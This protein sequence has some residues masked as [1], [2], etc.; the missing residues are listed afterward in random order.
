[1][2]SVQWRFL[3]ADLLT[4]AILAELQLVNVSFSQAL[5][6]AGT[7]QGEILLTGLSTASNA[8]NATIPGRTAIYAERQASDGTRVLLYGGILWNREYSSDNQRLKVTAREFESYFERRR[9]TSTINFAAVDQLTIAQTL[10]NNAQAVTGG[11]IGVIVPTN[12]SGVTVSKTYY[13]Y[14][15]KSV[16]SALQDLSRS[17]N[18]FDW[19]IKV[20][21][22]GSGNP[23]K[24]LYFNYPQSGVRYSAT[25][26]NAP[27]FE[28][29]AG[30][31]I[32]YTYPE[33]GAI[34]ANTI[35]AMGAGN[36]DGK[37]L[38]TAVD[39]T[40]VST[41]WPL[42]EDSVNYSDISD[43]TLLSNLAAGQIAAVSYPPTTLQIVTTASTAPV[44][45]TYN[46]G[47]DARVRIYDGARFPNGLDATYRITALSVNVG[48]GSGNSP[49]R[50]ILT[51]TLP[52]S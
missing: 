21:Y 35:Y 26:P 39:T 52:T 34:A 37:L 19:N 29:P 46:I 17:T 4:N 2:A 50:V 40:K 44:L 3:F 7:F 1:M 24:T 18:G 47:D 5:N 8:I 30:N 12:T 6:S 33:D 45:G 51:L 41:G 42:L 23:T 13:G 22:D 28:L 32:S 49:E 11:N 31:I 9:I 27:M 20:A 16:F 15:L 36:S 25:N 10:V 14:E 48:S 43:G 38:A